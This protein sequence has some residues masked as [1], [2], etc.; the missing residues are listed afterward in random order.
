MA[1][2]AYALSKG[3][4]AGAVAGVGVLDSQI[5]KEDAIEAETRASNRQIEAETRAADRKLSDAERMLAITEA[6]KNRAAERFGASVKAKMGTEVPATEDAASQ[7]RR[8][9]ANAT[10]TSPDATDSR[11]EAATGMLSQLDAS[12]P[13]EGQTRKL[14][15]E[16]AV[17]A[18]QEENFTN[19]P[20]AYMAGKAMATDKYITIADGASLWDTSTGK[21]VMQSTSKADRE[22]LREDRK[23]ARHAETIEMQE[24]RLNAT[25]SKVG[26]SGDKVMQHQYLTSL[27][28]DIS[29][30]AGRIKSIERTKKDLQFSPEALKEADAAIAELTATQ[31][32]LRRSKTQFARESGVKI[33]SA[34]QEKPAAAPAAAAPTKN[35][36]YDPATRTFK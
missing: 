23:D 8:A 34:Y 15:R 33:P 24:K 10:I 35:L 17:K 26:S 18:A 6:A 12:K 30:A 25:L 3:V 1:N 22:S 9:Q 16:E 7:Q 29:D 27:D 14:T 5:K 32:M 28:R 36:K 2:W 19:D 4:E 21:M 13:A 11:R 31:D 20:A